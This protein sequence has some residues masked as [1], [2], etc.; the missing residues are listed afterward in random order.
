MATAKF[1]VELEI[2]RTEE[3]TAQQYFFSYLS[4]RSLAAANADV[5][6]AMNTA[7]LFWKTV[8]HATLL[9]TFVALGRIFRPEIKAQ[10][11]HSSFGRSE[12]PQSVLKGS[13]N[14][15]ETLRRSH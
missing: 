2:F 15:A 10:H 14:G 11:R 13:T 12:G 7:P 6:D 1:E 5:L 8:H 4:I 9:S 3:E